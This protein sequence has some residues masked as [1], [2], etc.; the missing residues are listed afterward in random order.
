MPNNSAPKI[1]K[2]NGY[3]LLKKKLFVN[4]QETTLRSQMKLNKETLIIW[5]KNRESGYRNFDI[6]R[7]LYGPDNG[8]ADIRDFIKALDL[9]VN[10]FSR[11]A[12]GIIDIVHEIDREKMNTILLTK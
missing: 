4:L 3:F 11:K 1:K 9:N 5:L 2:K 10:F 6:K 8:I 7:K 12:S